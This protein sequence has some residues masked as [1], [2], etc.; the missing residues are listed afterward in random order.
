MEKSPHEVFLGTV[1]DNSRLRV[2]GC[3]ANV[4]VHREQGRGKLGDRTKRGVLLSNHDGIYRVMELERRISS[5][6]SM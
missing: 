5:S 1:P 2:F 3:L 4:F 6:Q